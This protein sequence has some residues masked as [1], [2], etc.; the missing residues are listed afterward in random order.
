M[1]LSRLSLCCLLPLAFGPGAAWAAKADRSQPIVMEADRPGTL[2][3]QRQ[4]LV[5][6]G[7]AVITQGTMVLRAD[8]IEM[9]EM[10]D[11]YRAASAIGLPGKPATW[12]QKRDGP[13]DEVVEGSAERIEFDGKADTLRFIGNGAVRRLRGGNVVD[14]I[15]GATIVWDNLAEVFKVEGGAV[16]PANPSGRVRVTLTP[17]AE[18]ASAPPAPV[19]AAL[20]PS[21]TLP[22]PR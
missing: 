12:R 22:S 20:Q 4:V 15:N 19:P 5:F 3:Y 9:R 18:A 13:A 1:L 17:R 10:A 6:N 11:G 2:D 8:R 16:T 14:E 21:R 7:N